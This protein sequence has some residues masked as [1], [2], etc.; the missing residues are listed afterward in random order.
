MAQNPSEQTS[1][2]L[3]RLSGVRQTG[4]GWQA[5]CPCREDDNNPSLAIGQGVDGRTLVT[6][7]RAMSCDVE[8]ICS[9]VGLKVS[10]LM[11]PDGNFVP[12]RDVFRPVK[13]NPVTST[14][15]NPPS[16]S[17]PK[18]VKAYDYT[19][20][21]GVLLFQKMRLVDDEGKK[22]F[23]QRKPDGS[24]GWVYSL[25]E[26]P[27]V[28]YNLPAVLEAKS[29]NIPIW[30]VEG[31]KDAD[32]LIDMGI[33]ATTMPGGAGKWLDIHTEALAGGIIE[34]VADNDEIGKKH[35]FDVFNEL[36]SAGCDSQLWICPSTK[37]I[38]DHLG[39]GEK[40]EDLIPLDASQQIEQ[41]QI[42][43][44]EIEE[45]SAE[46]LT[47]IKLNE[48]L[49]RDDLTAKQKIAK[50]NLIVAS[51]TVGH[52]LDTGRLVQWNDFLAESTNET[53][54]WVIPGLVERM[55]RVIVV[56]AEG[57]GKTMLARQIAIC[58]SAGIHPFSFQRMP[59]VRT[60][61]VDL[62]NPERIIRRTSRQIAAEAMSLSK[63]EKLEAYILTKPSGMD[64]LKAQDRSILE[65]AIEEVQPQMLVIGPLY[66]AFLD[67]GGR[68]SE[69]VALEV[70]KYLDT[71]RTVYNCSLWIE[72]HAPLGST[73][74]TRDLR[75]FGS[76][77]WSRWPEFG[78]SL[79]PDPTALGDYVYDVKH[80]RGAREER[81]WPL[82]M[83]RGK[84]FP[85]EV[86]DWMKVGP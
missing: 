49:N 37:D 70:A 34:I 64:L 48:L 10:D 6:C 53:H 20:E 28:L 55:E 32:T 12:S 17:K 76:A 58:C 73:M 62:E 8:K 24:G 36:Q 9:S 2:F 83:K 38:T 52:V 60:L 31:E 50:S 29:K 43:E 22:T 23:R 41:I 5:R 57:V 16:A 35:A 86:I 75:P 69:S 25:G 18:F 26:T 40:I 27:K 66:K 51:S 63:I 21:H 47:L 54:D 39:S 15:V 67:P 30:L 14:Q 46:E 59:Q 65:E 19:D 61:T 85:F 11:P 33:V 13:Q 4:N 1:N 45:L 77:V 80:F 84:R 3:N 79:Q 74:S 42:P 71:I 82:K 7:H 44:K 68:T 72:H 81:P 78:I 56:A